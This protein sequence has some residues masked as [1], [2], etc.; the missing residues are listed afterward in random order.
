[1]ASELQK[2]PISARKSFEYSSE[3]SSEMASKPTSID[4]EFHSIKKFSVSPKMTLASFNN[5]SGFNSVLQILMSIEDLVE[6]ISKLSSFG[7]CYNSEFLIQISLVFLAASHSHSGVVETEHFYSSLKFSDADPG[8][9]LQMLVNKLEVETCNS[10]SINLFLNG[11]VNKEIQCLACGKV[12][13]FES[14]FSYLA[15]KSSKSVKKSLE[16]FSRNS[17]QISFCSS[18][19]KENDCYVSNKIVQFPKYFLLVFKRWEEGLEKEECRFYA[20][21]SFGK[22]YRLVAV[23]SQVNKEVV[24]FCKRGKNWVAYEGEDWKKVQISN[25]LANSPYVLL[26]KLAN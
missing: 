6:F 26:Y 15:L 10:G 25:V 13:C 8:Q 18:C 9:I 4:Q 14:R 3:V 1:L 16:R 17:T 21:A 5:S 7:D 2:F 11:M 23:I 22:D 24:S 19:N 20:K 12:S